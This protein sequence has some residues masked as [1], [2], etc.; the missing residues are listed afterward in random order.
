MGNEMNDKFKKACEKKLK[1]EEFNNG[2]IKKFID[3]LKIK[4][5]FESF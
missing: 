2:E 1:E 3:S 5:M 4:F